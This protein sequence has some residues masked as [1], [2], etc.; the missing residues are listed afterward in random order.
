MLFKPAN[1]AKIIF[2]FDVSV[3]L[4]GDST[5]YGLSNPEWLGWNPSS[6]IRGPWVGQDA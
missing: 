4:K 2:K 6:T 1:F 3:Y 5:T